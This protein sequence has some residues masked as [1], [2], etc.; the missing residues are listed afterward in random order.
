MR[1]AIES[2]RSR[3]G[4]RSSSSSCS[5][6]RSTA[7]STRCR[8]RSRHSSRRVSTVSTSST[9]ESS[10][11]H[12]S[13]AARS[14]EDVAGLVE[15]DVGPA[16]VTLVR[17]EL[18]RPGEADDPGGAGWSFRHSL[19]RDVAYASIPKW[20][21][22]EL[23]ESLAARTLV[24][25]ADV[26]RGVPP[27]PGA[28]RA[29]RDRS[30]T[31]PTSQRIAAQAA[32]RF[33]AR[34]PRGRRPGRLRRGGVAARARERAFA[35]RRPGTNRVRADAR[36][37]CSSGSSGADAARELLEEASLP[38]RSSATCDSPREDRSR[39]D[40]DVD[41]RRGVAGADAARRRRRGGR[42]SSDDGDHEG[43][44]LAELLRFHALDQARLP[45]PGRAAA[46]RACVCAAGARPADR[47]ARHGL[48]LH[49]VAARKRSGGRG[50]RARRRDPAHVV[51][52]VRPR[53]CARSARPPS[54]GARRI[55]GGHGRSC[56]RTRAGARGARVATGVPRRTRSPSPRSRCWPATTRLPS[57]C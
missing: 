21:R 37:R 34:R 44:A 12:P 51:V 35:D 49:H 42:V 46:N 22:A 9:G 6:R 23:H 13:S 27:R 52:G 33:A 29:A 38:P 47:T 55:H 50:D 20:R 16:L 48:D 25:D 43:L 30:R 45:G 14:T 41:G 2:W 54:R 32:E 10:S 17:R 15:P 40:D 36:A 26:V 11:R 1:P 31:G 56:S 7:S 53:I 4:T 18:I 57:R 5:R 19:I 3:R 39:I 8:T 28:P 24:Q